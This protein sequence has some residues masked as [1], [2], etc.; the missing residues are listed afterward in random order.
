MLADRL[1]AGDLD[2]AR[3]LMPNLV[4]RDPRPAR[5]GGHG[6]GGD[7]VGRREH[8]PTPS[9]GRCCGARSP[10][11][12]GRRRA[13]GSSTPWTRWSAITASATSGFGYAAA[14][15]DDLAGL[16]PA[17]LTAALT[18]AAGAARSAGRRRG[19]WRAWRRDASAHP[20]PNAGPCEAA[21]AGALGVRLGGPTVYP[22]RAVRPAVAGRRARSR[23][24][25]CRTRGAAVARRDASPPRCVC[26]VLA[27]R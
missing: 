10:G 15:L 17:R 22:V 12:A 26:A 18:V 2:G 20:S 7:R 3:E 9:S 16:L 27:R 8:R 14:R 11:R 23:R 21:F 24:R 1:A 25:R 5:R 13:T 6:P 4:G 19:A